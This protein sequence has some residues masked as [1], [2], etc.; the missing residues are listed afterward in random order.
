MGRE[1]FS[2]R[3]PSLRG[4]SGTTSL[5]TRRVK[6]SRR[7]GLPTGLLRSAM[8][9][10][11]AMTDGG[12]VPFRNQLPIGR[13]TPQSTPLGGCCLEI[14]CRSG[15]QHHRARPLERVLFREWHQ[16]G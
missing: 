10:L 11:L 12:Q 9:R 1:L 3:Q 16:R 6:Q 5:R 15:E 8:C 4:A 14:G 13:A 2:G 7:G